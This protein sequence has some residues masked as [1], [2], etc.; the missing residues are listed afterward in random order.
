[1][2]TRTLVNSKIIADAHF[3]TRTFLEAFHFDVFARLGHFL[4]EDYGAV[5]Q[6]GHLKLGAEVAA[7]VLAGVEVQRVDSHLVDVAQL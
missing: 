7:E 4:L 1:M 5:Q 2:S 6:V 3:E